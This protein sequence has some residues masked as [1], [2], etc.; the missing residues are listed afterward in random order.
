MKLLLALFILVSCHS[1]AADSKNEFVRVS[2]RN[3]RYLE[4]TDGSPYIPIGLNMIAP[5]YTNAPQEEALLGLE[6]WLA[7]LSNNG[8]NYIRVW[9]SSPFWD[10]EHEKSGVYDAA[11]AQRIDRLLEKFRG[12]L[13]DAG[14]D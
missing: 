14:R 10:V 6:A 11:R 1:F 12:T 9:L 8:G 5:P 7:S 2:S 3:H 13:K 4:L